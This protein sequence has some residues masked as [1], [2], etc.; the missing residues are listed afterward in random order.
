MQRCAAVGLALIAALV[1]AA[2][3]NRADG[4]C[5]DLLAAIDKKPAA[6]EFVEC[7]ERPDLQGA[8]QQASYRVSG[9]HAADVERDLAKDLAVKTLHRT[10]CV[11]ESVE[12]SFRDKN[13]RLFV[14]AMA[15][16]DTKIDQREE[17]GKIPYF[18]VTVNLYRDDP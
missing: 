3:A 12:N 4:S 10:C 9:A 13:G 5:S 2:C 1:V 18:F 6:L 15:T 8:P 14:I 7:K 17:W 16:E 11:W